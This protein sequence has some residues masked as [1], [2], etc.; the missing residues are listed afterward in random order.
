MIALLARDLRLA[1]RQGGGFGLSLGF[2]LTLALLVPLSV[3]PRPAL[4]QSLGPGILW[5]GAAL[6]CL[7]SLDRLYA[8]DEE[9][10]TLEQLLLA[11]L[12][13]EG[14]VLMK[15]LAHW[16]VTGLPLVLL[17]PVLGL[18]F[19]LPPPGLWALGA[20][21]LLGSPALSLIGAF[22]AALTVGLR[23]GGLL[24]S[25]ITLPLYIP[26]LIFGADMA[27]RGAE[28]LALG[29]TPYV[30]AGLSLGSLALLP[31]AAAAALRA[32]LR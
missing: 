10:G 1:L 12:P 21:L 3:G 27:R 9:D 26:T 8:L 2:F 20:A 29:I 30:L 23:R 22:A 16:L 5:L 25:L 14:A 28:G 13:L 6:A 18:T 24:L 19:H 11:P 4:L 15:A 17:A 7:L 32:A 31:Y